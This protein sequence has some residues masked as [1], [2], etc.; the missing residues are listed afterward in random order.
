MFICSGSN[1]LYKISKNFQKW[2]KFCVQ[3]DFAAKSILVTLILNFKKYV[4]QNQHFL[5]FCAV[6]K[7]LCTCMVL[8]CPLP[9]KEKEKYIGQEV[10]QEFSYV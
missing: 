3:I 10:F 8:L 6:T 1:K 4:S 7:A 2:L 5:I 9:T